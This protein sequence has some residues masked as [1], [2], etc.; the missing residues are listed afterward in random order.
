ML[1]MTLFISRF[2][3][4]KTGVALRRTDDL[5]GLG[6]RIRCGIGRAFY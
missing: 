3:S 6:R 2:S 5:K 4:T 1:R